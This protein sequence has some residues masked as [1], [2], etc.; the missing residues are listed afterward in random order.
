MH[1]VATYMR[2]RP[3]VEEEYARRHAAVWPEVLAGISRYGIR[4]YSIYMHGRDLYSYFEVE[5]LEAAVALA[6]ADPVNQRW[7]EYM[8]PMMDQGSGM[9]DR[10]TVYLQEVFYLD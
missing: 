9:K 6:V 8:A 4:N 7:Q 1:R 2:V 5:D 3:G 10:S